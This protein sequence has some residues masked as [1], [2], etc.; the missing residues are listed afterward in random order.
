MRN[1]VRR[2]GSVF[3][4]NFVG[5]GSKEVLDSIY[6]YY[7]VGEY[8]RILWKRQYGFRKYY[9][10]YDRCIVQDYGSFFGITICYLNGMRYRLMNLQFDPVLDSGE[11]IPVYK[12]KK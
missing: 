7:Y 6:K 4:W 2:S 12:K 5:T 8:I 11:S 10:I 3:Y 9:L 1:N